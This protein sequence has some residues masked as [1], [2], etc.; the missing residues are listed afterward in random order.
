MDQKDKDI[1]W[2]ADD[3]PENC[4]YWSQK[5]LY[6]FVEKNVWEWTYIIDLWRNR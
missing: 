4:K 6:Y 1:L 2:A 5:K 3:L